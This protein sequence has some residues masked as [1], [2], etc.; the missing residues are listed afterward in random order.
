MQSYELFCI[1]TQKKTAHTWNIEKTCNQKRYSRIKTFGK[2]MKFKERERKKKKSAAAASTLIAWRDCVSFVMM[3]TFC[4]RSIRAM[5]Y[6]FVCPIQFRNRLAK[7]VRLN[8][9]Y[10][11]K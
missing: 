4:V 5:I 8:N 7:R 3:L 6:R 11:P 2:R 1:C 9:I 10:S